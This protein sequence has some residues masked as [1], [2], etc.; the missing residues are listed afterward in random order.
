MA[1][2][3]LVKIWVEGEMREKLDR[4]GL[5]KGQ[6]EPMLYDYLNDLIK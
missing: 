4:M 5:G 1:K 6:L 3:Y 2:R